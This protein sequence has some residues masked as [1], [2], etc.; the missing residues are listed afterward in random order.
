[1]LKWTLISRLRECLQNSGAVIL[2]RCKGIVE[3]I[4][5][6]PAPGQVVQERGQCSLGW[7]HIACLIGGEIVGRYR[8]G[9]PAVC[10]DEGQR[11][12][13]DVCSLHGWQQAPG[14]SFRP[15]GHS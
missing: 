9:G 5:N 3:P 12:R 4:A 15:K 14:T 2:E 8:A 1:M 10:I 6:R 13:V 11:A 7:F